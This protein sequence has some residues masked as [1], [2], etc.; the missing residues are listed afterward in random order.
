MKTFLLFVLLTAWV[1]QADR[2]VNFQVTQP[3]IVPH[4]NQQ[5]TIKLIEWVPAERR[6]WY[7][8]LI[9]STGETLPG[10]MAGEH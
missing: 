9:V 5:C 6:D 1:A 2:L 8:L 10:R 4:N 3:P 7:H